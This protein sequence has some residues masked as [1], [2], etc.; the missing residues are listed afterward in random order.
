MG[1][2]INIKFGKLHHDQLNIEIYKQ[3]EY[4]LMLTGTAIS[5]A[6]N[7][8][9]IINNR[10]NTHNIPK[11]TLIIGVRG[12]KFY[13]Y[14]L[15]KLSAYQL[16]IADIYIAVT[17]IVSLDGINV[18][19]L[20]PTIQIGKNSELLC[21]CEKFKGNII[22]IIKDAHNKLNGRIVFVAGLDKL[23]SWVK[24]TIGDDICSE[25]IICSY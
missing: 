24:L 25:N 1:Q 20:S 21:G 14:I 15:Q 23:I 17:G 11:F 3:R 6:F 2:D 9:D 19:N 16:L 12:E 5:I 18:A 8:L 13:N 7:L 22:R 4:I 10:F